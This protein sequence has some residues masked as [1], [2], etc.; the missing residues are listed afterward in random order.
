MCVPI[1][2]GITPDQTPAPSNDDDGGPDI[3]PQPAG[4]GEGFGF[5][6]GIGWTD[7]VDWSDPQG[8]I[9]ENITQSDEDS[10]TVAGT[11]GALV[12]GPIGAAISAFPVLSDLRNVAKMRTMQKVYE[13]AGMKDEAALIG[14]QVDK[15]LKSSP[16][17]IDRLDDATASGQGGYEA[18]LKKNGIDPENPDPAAVRKLIQSDGGT[19]DKP[20]PAPKPQQKPEDN[21]G[22]SSKNTD[23]FHKKI[24]EDA[25]ARKAKAEADVKSVQGQMVRTG[26]TA[27]QIGREMAPSEDKTSNVGSGAGGTATMNDSVSAK[28]ASDPRNNYKGGLMTKKKKKK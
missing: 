17:I 11:T 26:K 12:S 14:S 13:A 10:R 19:A 27:A 1:D 16:K 18:L 25:A 21:G 4:T 8:W 22:R 5:N 28:D 9:K 24:R 3:V 2:Q 20:K 7:D 6:L 23:D 15:Y